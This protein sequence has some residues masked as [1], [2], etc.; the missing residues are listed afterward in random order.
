VEDYNTPHELIVENLDKITVPTLL[1]YDQR[2][3]FAYTH[4][5]LRERLPNAKSVY[6]PDTEMRHFSPLEQPEL[7]LNYTKAFLLPEVS[8]AAE[9]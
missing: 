7:I 4:Q 2:S 6:L 1:I 5:V 3:P 8:P 9:V